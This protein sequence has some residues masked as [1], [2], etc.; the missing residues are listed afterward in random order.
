MDEF[1]RSLFVLASPCA[2]QVKLFPD[3]T[4]KGDEMVIEFGDAF[5]VLDKSELPVEGLNAL[6]TLD[7]YL[8]EHSGDAFAEHYLDNDLLNS[9]SIWVMI[10]K[11]ANDAIV[12]LDWQYEVPTSSGAEYIIDNEK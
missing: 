7:R 9:S 3:F 8:I 12:S 11:L 5:D 2:E 10:R 6:D 1:K 4:H